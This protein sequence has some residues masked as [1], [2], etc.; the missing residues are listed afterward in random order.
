MTDGWPYKYFSPRELGTRTTPQ[1]IQIAPPMPDIGYKGLGYRLDDLREAWGRPL[2]VTSCCRSKE[3]NARIGGNKRSF[4]VFDFDESDEHLF[5]DRPM[6]HYALAAD[7]AETSEEFRNLA[8][9]MS[10]SIGLGNTFTHIDDRF[11][12]YGMMQTRFK[13]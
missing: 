4:H 6:H 8:W 11:P 1:I 7:I 2:H 3:Y 9:A 10:F 5:T 12:I 13:Y